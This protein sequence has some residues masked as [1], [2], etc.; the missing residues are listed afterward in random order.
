MF[1]NPWFW[2]WLVTFVTWVASIRRWNRL[3]KKSDEQFWDM[4][5]Q[6]AEAI[7]ASA[8]FQRTLAHERERRIALAKSY[9]DDS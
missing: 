6:A 3:V 9:S 7:A 1:E 4:S 2:L 5:K 8:V